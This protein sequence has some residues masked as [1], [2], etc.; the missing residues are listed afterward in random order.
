MRQNRH[1]DRWPLAIAKT[2]LI[3]AFLYCA[4]IWIAVGILKLITMAPMN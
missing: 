3:I 4:V 2:A 1:K